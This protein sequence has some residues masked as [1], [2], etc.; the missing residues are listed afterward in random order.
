[1]RILDFDNNL[2]LKS[3]VLYL[4]K[5]E[6]EELS[7]SIKDL[8]LAEEDKNHSHVNDITYEHEITVVLYDDK[9]LESLNKRSQ[10]LIL[11]G[12]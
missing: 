8:I 9:N 10:D 7:S 3:V 5:E 11:Y 1:M 12:E 2:A 6:A 4:R